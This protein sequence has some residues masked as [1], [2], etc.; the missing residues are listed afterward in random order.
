ME[1]VM[2]KRALVVVTAFAAGLIAYPTL[3]ARTG[4]RLTAERR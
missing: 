3:T 2:G 4:V 1:V